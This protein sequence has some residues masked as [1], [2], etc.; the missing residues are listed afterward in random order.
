MKMISGSVVSE[1]GFEDFGLSRASNVGTKAINTTPNSIIA[2]RINS[3]FPRAQVKITQLL[4][5]TDDVSN[6]FLSVIL[7]KDVAVASVL[8]GVLTWNAV[9]DSVIEFNT[10][11]T[12][13]TIG[14]GVRILT[15]SINK[16]GILS[17]PSF[18]NIGNT[19]VLT[20]NISGLSDIL[21][22]SASAA[23]TT[24]VIICGLSWLEY[25]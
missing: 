3:S 25:L 6:V 14:T 19:A 2:I 16:Q 10:N 7:Y 4:A 17:L 1:G 24:D 20:S 18:N 15:G 5:T 9:T 22:I 13:L 23:T 12:T 11:A 8:G 21:V